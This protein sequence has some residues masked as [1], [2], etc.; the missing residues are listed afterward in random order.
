[1]EKRKLLDRMPMKHTWKAACLLAVWCMTSF[2]FAASFE[3]PDISKTVPV[4]V[5]LLSNAKPL[6]DTY[7]FSEPGASFIKVHFSQ[8]TLEEGVVV[9]VASPNRTEVYH[10]GTKHS[11]PRTM[12]GDDDG[13][14][15]FS[16][17]SVSGDTVEV[18]ILGAGGQSSA[19]IDHI[20]V[21]LPEPQVEQQLNGLDVETESI[22]GNSDDK[23][24]AS[25]FEFS[26]PTEYQHS[27]PVA[28][29]LIDGRKSC[30]AWRVGADNHVITNNHCVGDAR[31]A[32]S[33]ELWFNFQQ[34]YCGGERADI[35]KVSVDQL[36]ETDWTLDMSL[37]SVKD[38]DA[39]RAF[40]YLGL[41]PRIP[42][43]NETIYIPQHAGGRFKELGIYSDS[44]VIDAKSTNR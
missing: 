13:I 12:S 35:I 18:R 37:L 27:K 39:I 31:E 17:M 20:Q 30:T 16:A 38:F 5:R 10:Y 32:A 22:C 28:R 44:K 25:C 8:L 6:E 33:A 42:E 40:G 14:E 3:L 19:V 26:H 21:G 1:M 41:D 23:R 24:G 43:A 2:S 15:R 34:K 9:E 4:N 11:A 36:L 7:V 29:I